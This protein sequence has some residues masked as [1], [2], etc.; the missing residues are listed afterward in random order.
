M[1][2]S[3]LALGPTSSLRRG[4]ERDEPER[5]A[6]RGGNFVSGR[7]RVIGDRDPLFWLTALLFGAALVLGGAS[8]GAGWQHGLLEALSL[9]VIGLA[10]PRLKSM[11]VLKTLRAPLIIAACVM[12]IP[13]LQLVPLPFGVWASLPGRTDLAAAMQRFGAA[14]ALLPLSLTP[15]ETLNAFL[16]LLIPV[17]IFLGAA[18]CSSP[19]R[20][21]LLLM[22]VAAGI[23]SEVLG[24]VQLSDS[25]AS[26]RLYD[27][28]N[29]ERPVGL[30]A[31]R[32]HQ[33]LFL[34]I[35]LPL[36]AAWVRQQ[37][38]ER[39]RAMIGFGLLA[40]LGV[41]SVVA[42]TVSHSRAG[43]ALTVPAALGVLL[44]LFRSGLVKRRW[45]M[46]I[47]AVVLAAF[48]GG[49][50]LLSRSAWFAHRLVETG[51]GDYRQTIWSGALTLAHRYSPVGSGVGSFAEVYPAVERVETLQAA[52]VNHA[53]NIL[54]E[55]WAETG[56]IGLG[57]IAAFA[58][59]FGWR[60]LEAWR[61]SGASAAPGQ[62]ASIVIGLTAAHSLVDYPVQTPAIAAVIALSCALLAL[63]VRRAD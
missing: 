13:L 50:A 47:C 38:L 10:L 2:M 51:D 33:A 29:P 36:A 59:W 54:L 43:M 31:N 35:G 16:W 3:D 12:L 7:R 27:V 11:G 41:T 34:L 45:A 5:R 9:A 52:F 44:I 4:G 32:N 28:S 63:P 24:L 26:L 56:F 55:T 1:T 62:A 39:A 42:V 40:A 25:A 21:R 49:L 8:A 58:V 17:A 30:F 20:K 37:R 57:L 6:A 46:A 61:K 15:D 60:S 22:V 23:L 53:H 19:Q 48:A 14:P 18:A